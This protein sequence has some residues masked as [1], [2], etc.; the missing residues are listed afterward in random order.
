[1]YQRRAGSLAG[2]ALRV[3]APSRNLARVDNMYVMFI[4]ESGDHNLE[5][6]DPQ[7]PI[8]TLAGC[9]MDLDYHQEV[10]AP[11]LAQ[12]KEA[13]FGHANF[14]LHTAEITRRK[15]EFSK[16]TDPVF[17]NEFYE[18]I[19]RIISGLDF[20]VVACV[21]KKDEHLRQYGLAAIDPY[22]FSLRVL[23]E[24]FVFFLKE[25]DSSE[26]GFLVAEAREEHL[27]NKLKLVWMELR[28]SGTRYVS[29]QQIRRHLSA[30]LVIR[31]KNKNVAGLQIADLVVSPIGRRVLGK[32]PKQDWQVVREKIRKGPAGNYAGYGL[33]ILPNEKG[34]PRMTQ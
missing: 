8:F 25:K 2:P 34:G 5:V 17:R 23:V 24:R 12:F 28:N 27:D 13:L 16:L 33:V 26:P 6:I 3:L 7:Y 21:I 1:M 18:H 22:H 29:A 4:D 11:R 14:I 19:N 30:D 15:G 20:T 9:I 10:A 31:A 32:P